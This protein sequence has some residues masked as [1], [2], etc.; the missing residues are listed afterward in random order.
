MSEIFTFIIG[1]LLGTVFYGGLWLTVRNGL[2]SKHPAIWF[3]VS[4]WLRLAVAGLGFYLIAQDGD[5]KK[6][7]I[8]LTGFIIARLVITRLKQEPAHAH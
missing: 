5:W 7:L 8:C 6:L 1:L 3:L 2:N 4:F